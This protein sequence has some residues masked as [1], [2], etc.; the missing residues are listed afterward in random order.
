MSYFSKEELA[1]KHCLKLGKSVDDSYYFDEHF[2]ELLNS[3]RSDCGFALPISSGY[4]CTDHPINVQKYDDGKPL[5]AHAFGLAVDVVVDRKKAH[6]LLQ[7]AL[8]HG[9]PRI[10]V[11]QKGADRFIHLDCDISLPNPTIW[12]Y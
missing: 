3:I 5:G 8:E 9:V 12:S 6:R 7:V 11:N 2:L 1:C 4:R 10:G